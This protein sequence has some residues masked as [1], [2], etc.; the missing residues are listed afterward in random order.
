MKPM[1]QLFFFLIF[2]IY[3]RRECMGKNTNKYQQMLPQKNFLKRKIK[4][5]IKFFILVKVSLFNIFKQKNIFLSF[6]FRVN[7]FM[8]SVFSPLESLQTFWV[9]YITKIAIAFMTSKRFIGL[10][11]KY[12]YI[13]SKKYILLYV[14]V[15][16]EII[17]NRIY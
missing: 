15:F 6:Q 3:L 11:P 14:W 2:W 1:C 12:K 10:V 9:N 13:T 7:H 5:N 17:P 8:E 16:W 4:R